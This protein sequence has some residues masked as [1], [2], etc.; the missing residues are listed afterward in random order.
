MKKYYY[1]VFS[2]LLLF[3]LT[4]CGAYREKDYLDGPNGQWDNPND[5]DS[6]LEIIENS[7]QETIKNPNSYFS[8]DTSTAGYANFRRLVNNGA[9]IPKNSV[10][11]E[12]YINYF[13]YNYEA[14]T[15]DD[16]LK[17]S[18]EIMDSPWNS[19]NKLVSIGVKAKEIDLISKKQ[20]NIV[21]LIDVSGSMSAANKLPL[22]QEAFK[23][24]VDTLDNDDIIS[25]VT[26]ASGE[27]ILLDG[28]R[29]FE[30][31]KIMAVI[32]D[33]YAGGATAGAKGIQT[34]YQVAEKHFIEGG[35]NRVI[36]GT[37]GDFNVGISSTGDLKKFISDKRDKSNVYLS[38]LGFGYGNLRDDKLET[39]ANSGNGTYAYIDTINE[40]KKVLVDEIGGTLN[41]VSKDT[42]TKV[43][44][45]PR[46][47]KAYRLIGYENKLLSED[48]Y[49]NP[50]ADAGEIGAGHTATAVYEI[51]LNDNLD[52]ESTLENNWLEVEITYK[53]PDTNE[54]K[55]ISK[56]INESFIRITP[57]EDIL[58]ISSLIET[59]LVLRDSK[60]KGEASLRNAYD[61]IK[62]LPSVQL[63]PYRLEFKDL[64]KKLL[65]RL[66]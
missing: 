34:A 49:K 23:L 38:V 11:I 13:K 19:G 33:L 45:N 2:L 48:D 5:E 6:Y 22:L 32:E 47:V 24:F 58:F 27:K 43:M 41:I 52:V 35:H 29:G 4:S 20:S 18:G 44:F 56:L 57:S 14:P 10:K 26:Y 21:L 53:D 66:G 40:A 51:I 15:N 3:V 64:L 62:S 12:E 59:G 25:V 8:L 17:I 55:V 37:D 9:S 65:D 54:S 46:Y 42:K 31:A 50:R 16:A 30:K 36:I 63:D 28:A 61:R 7:F 39:L 60:Y 1:F